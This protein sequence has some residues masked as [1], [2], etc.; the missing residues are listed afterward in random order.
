MRRSYDDKYK[1]LAAR[2]KKKRKKEKERI[3]PP[4][5]EFDGLFYLKFNYFALKATY[6]VVHVTIKS[7]LKRFIDISFGLRDIDTSTVPNHVY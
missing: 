6:Y 4:P 1:A 7:P 5:A 3:K 2:A